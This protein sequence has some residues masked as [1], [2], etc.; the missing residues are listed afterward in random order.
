VA[1]ILA[2]FFTLLSMAL[3][4]FTVEV[5]RGNPFVPDG[6]STPDDVLGS[7]RAVV[8][9]SL[10]GAVGAAYYLWSD[11]VHQFSE[12]EVGAIVGEAVYLLDR[13]DD[14]LPEV[15]EDSGDLDGLRVLRARGDA[16]N[17]DAWLVTDDDGGSPYCV[18]SRVDGGG[19]DEVRWYYG[20]GLC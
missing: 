2:L 10:V 18:W 14:S 3:L 20:P 4:W 8:V 6:D 13:S 5:F 1:L 19:S 12:E 15:L 17:L 16:D 7:L 9:L 11:R